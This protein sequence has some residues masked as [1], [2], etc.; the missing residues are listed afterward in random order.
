MSKLTIPDLSMRDLKMMA[1][2]HKSN[3]GMINKIQVHTTKERVLLLCRDEPT[4]K[5]IDILRSAWIK[6]EG[7]WFEL[8]IN[9]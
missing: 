7:I 5:N 2:K 4:H 9:K 8:M 6:V 3:K 1:K